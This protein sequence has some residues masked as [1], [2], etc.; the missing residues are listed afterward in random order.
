MIY[1]NNIIIIICQS[2][3]APVS[4]AKKKKAVGAVGRVHWSEAVIIYHTQCMGFILR[5]RAS[6]GVGPVIVDLCL[7]GTC[8]TIRQQ[9]DA[10]H[11]PLEAPRGDGSRLQH[12]ISLVRRRWL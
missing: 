7:P 6:T 4:Q 3:T 12:S 2:I 10:G 5:Q 9:D 8:I 1:Y 11:G